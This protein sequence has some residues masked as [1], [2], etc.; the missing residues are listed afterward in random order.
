MRP[1]AASLAQI[2]LLAL[3]PHNGTLCFAGTPA[4]KAA[5]S[6]MSD[7][8][9]M[10][11]QAKLTFAGLTSIKSAGAFVAPIF[12]TTNTH[13]RE[14]YKVEHF[15]TVDRTTS[16]DATH[17]SYYPGPGLHLKLQQP[18][19]GPPE[20]WEISEEMSDLIRQGE[21]EHLD[22]ARRAFELTYKCVEN[23]INSLVGRKFGPA[24][25]PNGAAALALQELEKRIPKELG[26]DPGNWTK[27]LDRLLLMT[28]ERDKLLMHAIQLGSAREEDGKYIETLVASAFFR[29]GQTSSSQIVNL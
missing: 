17:D 8:V 16:Q 1:Q 23:H 9:R 13:K 19:K 7:I 27:Q 21:Q 11:K 6:G 2:A 24:T 4:R 10:S 26:T 25:N 22:D 5:P 20:Y 15:A 3:K 29:V 12:Q 14:G 28:T 18:K